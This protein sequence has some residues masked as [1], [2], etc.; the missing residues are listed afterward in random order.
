MTSNEKMPPGYGC[1]ACNR[2]VVRGDKWW[3]LAKTSTATVVLC[4]DCSNRRALAKGV[5]YMLVPG[6]QDDQ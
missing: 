1:A 4:G 5:G 2:R 3:S 6:K